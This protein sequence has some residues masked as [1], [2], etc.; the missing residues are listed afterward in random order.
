[1]GYLRFLAVLADCLNALAV[2]APLA[3]GLRIFSP[4]PLAIL[5]RLAWILAYNPLLAINH[6]FVL[7]DQYR[8]DNLDGLLS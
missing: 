7:C 8:A 5:F 2:G 1:M 3:P 6:H 4:L